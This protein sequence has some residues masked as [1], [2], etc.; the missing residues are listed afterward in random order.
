MGLGAIVQRRRARVAG[1]AELL[2]NSRILADGDVYYEDCHATDARWILALKNLIAPERL[3]ER[4]RYGQVLPLP[5]PLTRATAPAA[6]DTNGADGRVAELVRSLKRDGVAILKSDPRTTRH[7]ANRFGSDPT[8]YEPSDHYW[9]TWVSPTADETIRAWCL[10]PLVLATVARYYRAQPYLRDVPT[11]NVTY[12]S[13][14]SAEARHLETDYASNWH[15]DTPNLVSVHLLLHDIGPEDTRMLYARGSHKRFH[16][17]L[18]DSDRWHSD[19][20]VRAQY[21]V[22]DCV[23][24]AGT[25]YI[26]DNNGLHRLE[27]VKGSFRSTFEAYFTPGNALITLAA[28]RTLEETSSIKLDPSVMDD[29]DLPADLSDLQR[30]SLSGL[31]GKHR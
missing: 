15:Y 22:M 21:P 3:L 20:Y 24:E 31:L 1:R 11:V 7:I 19:E 25:A 16:T 30:E 28:R 6:H 9:R 26:F 13:V 17:H 4:A 2:L 14:T 29:F 5:A 27:A 18:G 23:G 12:P 8:R 10:D